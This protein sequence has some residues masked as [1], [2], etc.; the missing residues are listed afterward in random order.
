VI[1]ASEE[2]TLSANSVFDP[3]IFSGGDFSQLQSA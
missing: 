3:A 1:A 2:T